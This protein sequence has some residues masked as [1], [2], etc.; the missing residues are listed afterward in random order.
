MR[1]L[2]V[3]NFT[4]LN[5]FYKGANDDI[6]WHKHGGDEGFAAEGA[7]S[8]STLVFGRVTYEMMN[9]FWP[10]PEALAAMPE[11]AKGM[12]AAEKIVFSNTLKTASWNNTRIVKGDIIEEMKKLKQQPGAGLTILG[13]GSIVTQFAE[14]GLI[15]NFMLMVDPVAIGEGTSLFKGLTHPLELKLTDTRTFKNG[16]VLLNYQR[17]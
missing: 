10:T 9:R 12:N 7:G 6:S 1:K 5:G 2:S 8:G 3:F 4:T 16:M 14:H 13:S 11:V 15:D 17:K